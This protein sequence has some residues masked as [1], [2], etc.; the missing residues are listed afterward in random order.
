MCLADVSGRQ[1]EAGNRKFQEDAVKELLRVES[2]ARIPELMR[3]AFEVATR[4]RPGPVIV[5]LL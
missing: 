4:G 2:I 1:Q 3:R 5:R